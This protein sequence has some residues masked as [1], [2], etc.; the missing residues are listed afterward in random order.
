[1]AKFNAAGTTLVYSTY[2]GGEG[3]DWGEGIAVDARGQMYIT[4]MTESQDF[5]TQKALQPTL[6]GF[7]DAFVIKLNA[8]GSTLLYSTYLG[9]HE[10]DWGHG[11]AVDRRG[12][13]Y[14]VG[15][16]QSDDFPTTPNALQSVLGSTPEESGWVPSDAFVAKLNATGS[17]LAYST[18]IGGHGG[19]SAAAIAVD[20]QG[21]ASVVGYTWSEN[22]PTHQ[23]LQSSPSAD[24]D[25]FAMQ[26]NT[27]GSALVYS[28][29]LGGSKSDVG[30]DIA[31]DPRGQ[32]YITGYTNS[33]DFPTTPQS[34]Q[35]EFSGGE[36]YGMDAF[37]VKLSRLPLR[38]QQQQG[39]KKRM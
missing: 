6:K 13:A 22:F 12:Q 4:G 35:P 21:R 16:T 20:S 2:L 25:M 10:T 8:A 39:W 36:D 32:A 19:D 33:E 1:V 3:S 15:F 18:Y 7:R 11:I 38:P 34:L 27:A 29:C 37:V 24:G 23:A 14:V 9:G 31:L 28:T 26:L 5:P 17:E 30:A